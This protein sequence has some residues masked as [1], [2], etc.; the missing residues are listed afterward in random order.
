MKNIILFF[1]LFNKGFLFA[2]KERNSDNFLC[3]KIAPLSLLDIYSGMSPR[4]GVEYKIKN[5]YTIYNEIGSYI[6]N[7]N[8]NTNNKGIL[9]KIE[10]KYY[11][12]EPKL[13][14]NKYISGELFYKHQSFNSYDTI[15]INSIKYFKDYHVSKDVGCI[16]IKYGVLVQ[17][18]Y[19]IVLDYFIGLG[20]RYKNSKSSLTEDENRNIKPDGIYQANVNLSK[21][22]TF[23]YLNFDMGIKIG[24]R[25]N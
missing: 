11:F 14:V 13:K 1:L 15:Q 3:V 25:I 9:T 8:S 20:Y 21:A 10:L 2:Q 17:Y 7:V 5:S 4:I 19:K 22:G 24:Y 18:K 16:T 23:T 12:Y 6:P